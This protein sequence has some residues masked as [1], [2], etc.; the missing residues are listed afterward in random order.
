MLC[1]PGAYDYSKE[2]TDLTTDNNNNNAHQNS[3]YISA[4]MMRSVVDFLAG[5]GLDAA[6]LAEGAGYALPDLSNDDAVINA[7]IYPALMQAAIDAT[8]QDDLG[9]QFGKLAKPERWGVL[10]YIMSSCNTLAEAIQCQ[11]RFQQL[12]GSIGQIQVAVNGPYIRLLYVTDEDPIRPLVEEAVS[13]WI[14]YGRWVT[15]LPKSPQQVFFKHPPPVDVKPFE[16]YF[17]CPV[18]FNAEING[19]EFPFT[20]LNIPLRQPDE[21]H[22]DWLFNVA[23]EKLSQLQATPDYLMKAKKYIAEQLPKQVPE[24]TEVADHLD[25]N[26][27]A[28]QR[29][30][31]KENLTYKQL[32]ETIRTD[33]AK[34]FLK[35][36]RYSIIEIT[37]LLGFSEQSAFTRAFKRAVGVSPGEY[38]RMDLIRQNALGN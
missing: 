22:K 17:Q 31:K 19:L 14:A 3:K 30:L 9:F 1:G 24:L 33:M 37:F 21:E 36:S 28:L 10:G 26:S 11:Q 23:E 32:L 4:A 7:D 8:G 35:H 18:H 15:G 13:G 6:Q 38:R 25:L 20:F 12:V 27:R 2:G 29:R 34:R 16:V 5:K